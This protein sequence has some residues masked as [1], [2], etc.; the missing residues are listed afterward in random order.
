MVSFFYQAVTLT[1]MIFG[2]D[3]PFIR[4]IPFIPIYC[5][6]AFYTYNL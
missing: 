4:Y 5:S 1:V 2:T 3:I 6:T